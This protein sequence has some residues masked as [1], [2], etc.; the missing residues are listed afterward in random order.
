MELYNFISEL[1]RSEG[2]TLFASLPL[3]HCN[4]VKPYLLE[5][6]GIT[7]GSAVICAVP[8]F[9]EQLIGEHNI[10]AYCA[11]KDYHLFFEKLK[12][13][14]LTELKNHYPE[15]KFEFFADHSP[16][17]ERNAAASAGLGVIG[18]NGMLITE[19]YSSYVF[20]GELICNAKLPFQ[21][22][23]IEY[24]IGCKKCLAECPTRKDGICLSAI[25]QKKGELT[26]TESELMKKHNT[27]WGCD[28]CQKTCPYTEKAIKNGTVFT[29][30]DYFLTDIIPDLD[31]NVLS[32][33]SDEEFSFRA[34]S[35]RG[36][37]TVERNLK[38]LEKKS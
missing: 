12:T 13:K 35:W 1:F 37:A 38:I 36:K 2:I 10:S 8:Y 27:A 5:K 16:I 23:E 24:C 17:D 32:A 20:L 21:L 9:S 25:T 3:S 4:I 11:V 7:D 29:N 33:L 18:L 14:L 34:F 15:Y 19:K 6:A 31:C 30:I 22:K 26:D 28:I